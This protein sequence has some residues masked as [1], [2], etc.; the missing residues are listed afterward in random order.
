[1]FTLLVD[2]GTH[3][4][5]AELLVL[6]TCS[7][8]RGAGYQHEDR[9]SCLT[10]TREAILD[11]IES[12][13]KDFNKPP[14]YWLNGLAGTGKSTIAQ[15]TAERL[16]ADGQLGAS[17]FCSRDFK[18]RSDLHFIFPTLSIQLAHRYPK[19]RSVLIPLLQSDLDIGYE[20]LHSQMKKLIVSPLKEAD[21]STVIVIDALDECADDESQSAILSVMGRLVEEIPMVKFFITG[22]PEPHIQSGFRL[23]LLRPLTEIFVLHA[24]G[25]SIVYMDIQRFLQT[26]LSELAQKFQLTGWP[27]DEHI[28]LLCQRAAGLFVYAVATIRFLDH[29]AYPP[30]QQLNAITA[31]PEC[32][33]FEGETP[34]RDKTTLDSL[35]TSILQ[36]ALEFGPV[37]P[38]LDSKVQSIIGT[39]V[40]LINP[41]P[42]SAVAELI[43]LEIRQVKMILT[44]VQSLLILSEDPNC[45]VKPFHKSFPD[46]I[47]DSS[48]CLNKRFYI[49]PGTLHY[50]LTINC[51]KLMNDNLEPNLL[52]LPD[53]ALNQEVKDLADRIKV[54]ISP[55]LEYACRSWYSHLIKTR[56]GTTH[57]LDTLYIFLR[58]KFLPWLE[59]ISIL[60]A[61]RGTVPGLE[62]LVMWLQQVHFNLL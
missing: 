54:H 48:R 11:E 51:L 24:V 17:F 44:L 18:D 45:P 13:S 28:N 50:E 27:S 16:F 22:R 55:A 49:S 61:T 21:I 35:Y 53:Y 5:T 42:L 47:T 29:K 10:G 26:R 39:V 25:H 57:I 23:Q 58:K 62:N 19:F 3:V 52:S 38:G 30:D 15:T 32:T 36:M 14:I 43:G 12:W 37:D 1:M 20:S 31:L 60:G 33:T 56:E 8:A 34:F 2:V 59:V 4:L 7:R 6:N 46:F 9:H 41:L 40:L